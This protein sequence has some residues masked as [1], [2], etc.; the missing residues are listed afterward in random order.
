[1]WAWVSVM[2]DCRAPDWVSLL[3]QLDGTGAKTAV[4]SFGPNGVLARTTTTRP[5]LYSQFIACFLK[6]TLEQPPQSTRLTEFR[7]QYWPCRIAVIEET[8]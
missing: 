1:V 2:L 6:K 4:M 3:E 7:S 5:L 8:F